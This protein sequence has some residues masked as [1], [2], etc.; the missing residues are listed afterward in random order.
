MQGSFFYK[1]RLF[2]THQSAIREAPKVFSRLPSR[3]AADKPCPVLQPSLSMGGQLGK[4]VVSKMLTSTNL[5]VVML[6]K[7]AYINHANVICESS[8][9]LLGVLIFLNEQKSETSRQIHSS[10]DS[11]KAL[12]S[13]DQHC[14]FHFATKQWYFVTKI[15]LTYNQKKLFQ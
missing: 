9:I 6:S 1:K 5:Q 15:V 14:N 8:L 10:Y 2:S 13:K 3:M 11:A 4:Y 12:K 7:N